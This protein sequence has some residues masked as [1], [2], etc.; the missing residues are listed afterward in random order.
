MPL[1]R[2]LSPI[3]EQL[4]RLQPRWTTL[5]DMP[6]V[7]DFGDLARERDLIGRLALCDVSALDRLVVKGPGAAEFLASQG[8]WVP[9]QIYG[10]LPQAEGGLIVR[11][12]GAEFFLENDWQG[13][14]VERLRAA[15]DAA[16]PGVYG[17]PRQDISLVV[18]GSAAL[19]LFSQ[20]CGYNFDDSGYRFVM[21]QLAGVSCSVL[22]R[23]LGIARA[24]QLWADG[25]YGAYLWETLLEIARELGGDAVGIGAL[26]HSL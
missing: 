9:D 4:T 8:L 7:S 24:W 11:T 10:H 23:Q 16:V 26:Q 14:L 15:L 25:S 19:V 22:P 20:T 18:S 3:H 21:T 1:P 13:G 5:G 17:V 2:R 12:G 6:A